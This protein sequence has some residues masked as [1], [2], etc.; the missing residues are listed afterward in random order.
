[1]KNLILFPQPPVSDSNPGPDFQK[2]HFVL[3]APG[4]RVALDLYSRVT[5][6]SR[7]NVPDQETSKARRPKPTVGRPA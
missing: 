5:D 6:L 1:M 7:P 4:R 2:H 3:Q